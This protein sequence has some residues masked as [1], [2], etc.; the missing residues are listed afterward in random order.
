MN[1]YTFIL[2]SALFLGAC[3]S[4]NTQ[5][6]NNA[7]K[8]VESKALEPFVENHEFSSLTLESEIGLRGFSFP[9]AEG[10]WTED[11]YV[12][13]GI[14]CKAKNNQTIIFDAIPYINKEHPSME[15]SVYVSDSLISEWSFEN[16][17]KTTPISVVVTPDMATENNIQLKLKI[18]SPKSPKELG[19]GED[20]RKL[21]L[22]FKKITIYGF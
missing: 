18:K 19:R 22:F 1:K 8:K 3:S 15:V 7:E 12:Y 17:Q 21:G 2:F 10:R 16:G 13:L 6:K 11:N 4:N 9:E 5:D 14:P 20:N